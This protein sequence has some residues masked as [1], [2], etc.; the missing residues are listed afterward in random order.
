MQDTTTRQA[1]DAAGYVTNAPTMSAPSVYALNMRASSILLTELLN[2]VTGYRRTA[3]TYF[4]SW[5]R[6]LAVRIDG[7]TFNDIPAEDCRTCF[8]Y[9]GRGDTEPLPQ[10]GEFTADSNGVLSNAQQFTVDACSTKA[11]LPAAGSTP[12]GT[13]SSRHKLAQA[14]AGAHKY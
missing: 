6:D 4:D 3:T 12:V 13:A 11:P 1:R 8:Y 10:P 2:F 14:I 7:S 5:H 9:H